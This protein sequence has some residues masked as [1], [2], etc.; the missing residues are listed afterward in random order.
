MY[1]VGER[2]TREVGPSIG[3]GVWWQARRLH[4]RLDL[5]S[6]DFVDVRV[7]TWVKSAHG[8]WRWTYYARSVLCDV[9]KVCDLPVRVLY[10]HIDVGRF[11]LDGD[12]TDASTN[13]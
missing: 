8:R 5:L 1:V 7:H 2:S 4:V 11:L 3:G 6:G 10:L 12:S 13:Y 9:S